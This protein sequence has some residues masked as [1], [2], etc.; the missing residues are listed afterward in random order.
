ML[1]MS[2]INTLDILTINCN[3]I[4]TREA[5]ITNKCSAITANCQGSCCEQHYTNMIQ[6]AARPQ[7]CYTNIDSMSK[8]NNKDKPM[9]NNQLSNTVEYFLPGLSYNSDTKRVLNSHSD[10]KGTLKMYLMELC[11]LM[12]H[13]HCS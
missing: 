3:T 4:G 11:A 2:N 7:K 5:D 1:G 9:V 8:S 13:F 12:G 6:E 10:Y